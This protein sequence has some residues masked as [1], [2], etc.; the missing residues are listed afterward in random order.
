MVRGS[1]VLFSTATLNRRWGFKDVQD[2]YTTEL[3]GAE[4]TTIND[5][6]KEITVERTKWIQSDE[7][8][9]IAR[10]DLTPLA[11][12]WYHTV[13]TKILPTAHLE[14]VNKERLVLLYCILK[15][16]K[17]DLGHIIEREI[18]SCSFKPK[19]LLFFPSLITSLCLKSEVKT[20]LGE[21]VIANK[22]VIDCLAIKQ[23]A[24]STSKVTAQEPPSG[25]RITQ[26]IGR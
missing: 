9:K 17:V 3:K 20:K 15:E 8:W 1:K 18:I 24:G 12:V 11:K 25:S 14:T 7:N 21:E 4:E 6:M 23:F 2:E 22:G 26:R 5:M 13:R 16:K 19:G 10:P